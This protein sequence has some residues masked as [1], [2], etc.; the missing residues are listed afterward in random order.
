MTTSLAHLP[1]TILN[2]RRADWDSSWVEDISNPPFREQVEWELN[3][4]AAA[5][6]IA[7]YFDNDTKAPISLMELGL[8][9][10]SGK[11]IVCCPQGYWKRGNVQIVC[12]RFGVRVVE[13]L[14][15]LVEGV[16]GMMRDLGVGEVEPLSAS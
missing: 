13:T 7:M 2:P 16:V 3:A 5:D 14:G 15:E 12:A 9:V 8:H 11:M 6:I 10:K 4:L 1:I